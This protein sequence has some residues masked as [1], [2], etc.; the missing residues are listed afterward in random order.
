MQLLGDDI[1][2]PTTNGAPDAQ[3][4]QNALESIFGGLGEATAATPS[5][6][7][8]RQATVNDILGLFDSPAAP[9]ASAPT[10]AAAQLNSLFASATPAA[11]AP[12]PVP[13]P[14]PVTQAAAAVAST[15]YTAYQKNN[16]QITLTPQTSAARPGIVNIMARF[17]VS[18]ANSATNVNFQAAVPKVSDL[19]MCSCVGPNVW[20]YL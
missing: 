4:A 2:T 12:A 18:G 20:L 17:Q 1:I 16:L 19:L 10:T 11:P 7:S 5:Q 14:K 3:S 9:P 15:S 8:S 6:T 13:V